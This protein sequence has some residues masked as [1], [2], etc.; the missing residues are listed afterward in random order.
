MSY[1]PMNTVG[2]V[3]Q[4]W[5]ACAL[6]P[7][8]CRLTVNLRRAALAARFVVLVCGVTPFVLWAGVDGGPDTH[9]SVKNENA[10][11][12][13]VTP[14]GAVVKCATASTYRLPGHV[15]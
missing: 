11:T 14:Y 7:V 12:V 5:A 2:A 8:A 3:S 9:P 13:P 10:M 1:P 4:V 15:G 6:H